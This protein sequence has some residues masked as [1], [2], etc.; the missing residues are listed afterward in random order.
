MKY[1]LK[2]SSVFLDGTFIKKD[3]LIE[4]GIVADISSTISPIST[5]VSFDLNNCFVFPGLID[6]HV[7]LREPGYFYKE[8]ILSGSLAAAHGGFTTVCAMPNLNPVPDCMESL[9]RQLEIIE[10]DAVIEVLPYGSITVGEKQTELSDME[11]LASHV[12]AFSD[13][14]VGVQSAEMMETAMRRAKKLGKI[15]A[16]HCELNELLKGGCIHDGE[17]A[18]RNG[19]KGISSES[20][21]RAIERDIELVRKTGCEYHVCHIST[22]ESVD[23][24]RKAKAEGLPISCETAPHYLVFCDEELRDEGRFK[25]NPPIRSSLDRQALL[26]GIRDGTI[27]MIA[28]DHAPHSE[29]E[30]SRGLQGSLNG[31]VGLETSFP[32]LYTKLVKG[33]FISLEKLI[34]LM[35]VNPSRRFGIGCALEIGQAANL[36]VF[37]LNSEYI[38]DPK[39]FFSKGRST[40][41]EGMRVYGKCLMTMVSGVPVWEDRSL[42]GTVAKCGEV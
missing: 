4:D 18:K 39:E 10:K 42:R 31:I 32:T 41:F 40:P 28:T 35:Q 29:E 13:D 11:A 27:D 12:C 20:E 25:M 22:K 37:D 26:D 2:N 21:W 23:L 5:A 38:I 1:L 3:V 19:F 15:I 17:Y 16:A 8:S 24:I 6:V 34:E 7:H 33:G 36:T 30:K 14:G 9:N